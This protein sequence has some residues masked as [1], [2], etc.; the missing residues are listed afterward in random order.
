M[1]FRDDTCRALDRLALTAQRDG[2]VPGLAAGVARRGALQW[3]RGVGT[4]DLARP[5]DTPDED[6]QY[7]VASNSK[8][9]TAVAIMALRDEGRLDL[10]DTVDRY[11]AGTVHEGVTIRQLLSHTSGMQR[12]PVGGIFDTMVMPEREDLVAGWDEAA[13]VGRPHD[14]WHYSNL[15]YSMLGEVVARLDGCGWEESI[16]R[17]ILG[18]LEMRRTGTRPSGRRAKGYYVPPFSDVPVPEPE[19]DAKALDPAGGLRSTPA[20]LAR[21]GAFVADPVA[22]VLAPDTLEEM[23]QPQTMADATGWTMAWSLGLQ[24]LRKEGRTWVGHTGG[25]PGSVTGCFTERDSR[26]TA[27]LLMNQTNPVPPAAAAIGMGHEAVER[28]P[29]ELE[30]WVPG[31]EIPEG[32]AE[33][34]GHWYSEGTGFVLSVREGKLEARVEGAAKG[35]PPAVFERVDERTYRTVSGRERG[36]VLTVERSSDGSVSHLTWATYRFTREPLAFGQWL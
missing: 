4:I 21:W 35:D 27:V 26:T 24:L 8:T 2:R 23:C 29:A 31:S 10:D 12:E 36:E 14:R 13:R 3:F 16:R 5:A 7:P 15:A 34:L 9:F 28:E 19:F 1:T 18:P 30:P 20:D 33:L 6:T 32:L 11:V 25:W 17:R 22:E